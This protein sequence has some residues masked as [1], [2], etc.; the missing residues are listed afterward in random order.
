LPAV[1]HLLVRFFVAITDSDWFS[2]LS[3][4]GPL[5]EVNF[6]QPSGS[7][8]LKHFFLE[9]HF[10]LNCAVSM[11]SLLAEDFSAT[12]AISSAKYLA[13]R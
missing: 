1:D 12:T 10:Y 8:D 3:S 2:Y 5:D 13:G 9:S 7:V 11:I 6:W 4:F